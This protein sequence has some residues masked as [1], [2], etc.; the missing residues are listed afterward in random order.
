MNQCK[1]CRFFKV[2]GTRRKPWRDYGECRRRAPLMRGDI[3][4]DPPGGVQPCVAMWPLVGEDD[5]CGEWAPAQE[6]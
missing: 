3:D 2:M 4:K 5:G 1:S 6:D